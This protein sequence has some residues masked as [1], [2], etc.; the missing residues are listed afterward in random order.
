MRQG[1]ELLSRKAGEEWREERE[2]KRRGGREGGRLTV[3]LTT[4][5]FLAET[6]FAG[7]AE[8]FFAPFS[9]TAVSPRF[10][11]DLLPPTSPFPI[12]PCT[13]FATAAASLTFPEAPLG[14]SNVPFSA[15][16]LIAEFTR[17]SNAVP[18]EIPGYCARMNL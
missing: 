1:L 16:R 14:I 9:S 8:A 17:A 5:D 10:K 15:P 13:G 7:A 3:A 11:G 2:W 18:G 6:F 4:A 12:E